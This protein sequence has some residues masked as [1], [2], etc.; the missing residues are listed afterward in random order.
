MGVIFDYKKLTSEEFQLIEAIVERCRGIWKPP[1]RTL[2]QDLMTVHVADAG[3]PLDFA[4]LLNSPQYDF[5]HD[6]AGI[7]QYLDRQTG[8]LEEFFVPRCAK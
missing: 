5:T 6:I 2:W 3:C 4:A 8:K 7:Y 1:P